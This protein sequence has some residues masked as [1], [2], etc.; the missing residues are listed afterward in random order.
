MT[1]SR[2]QQLAIAALD[3]FKAVAQEAM[4]LVA[5]SRV[6]PISGADQPPTEQ[7][8]RDFKVGCLLVPA[9]QASQHV[10]QAAAL[11]CGQAGVGKVL[12]VDRADE[13]LDRVKPVMCHFI[14]GNDRSKRLARLCLAE[15]CQLRAT[16]RG[17][18]MVADL[19]IP[20]SGK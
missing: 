11:G 8:G 15:K 20:A 17:S 16:R 2:A 3:H 10:A 4:R 19:V 13:T 12:P 9:I 18:H 7:G 1:P 5:E 6:M 14:E